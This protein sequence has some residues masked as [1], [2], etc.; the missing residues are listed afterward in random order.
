MS[1]AIPL[2][3]AVTSHKMGNSS[4]EHRY[5]SST[6]DSTSTFRTSPTGSRFYTRKEANASLAAAAY[7]KLTGR[8]GV[9]LATSGPGAS[10][11]TTG[12][13]DAVQDRVPMLALTGMQR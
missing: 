12:L 6:Y 5:L 9:C 4:P 8:M 11:L 10:N 1:P 2:P 13:I 3:W 7:A